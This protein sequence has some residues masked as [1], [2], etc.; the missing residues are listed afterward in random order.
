MRKDLAVDAQAIGYLVEVFLEVFESPDKVR[1]KDPLPGSQKQI[2]RDEMDPGNVQTQ[3]GDSSGSPSDGSDPVEF[4]PVVVNPDDEMVEGRKVIKEFRAI[5][6][7]RGN[8]IEWISNEGPD[9]KVVVQYS[10]RFVF[11]DRVMPGSAIPGDGG[12]RSPGGL[13]D[14][15]EQRSQVLV[16]NAHL[17]NRKQ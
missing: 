12:H 3:V 4:F 5:F 13:R 7:G 6:I 2:L 17:F 11:G 16:V 1:T 8:P 10:P 14:V 15:N 9:E